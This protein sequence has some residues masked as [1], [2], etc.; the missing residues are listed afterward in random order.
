[1]IDVTTPVNS[2]PSGPNAR[3][4]KGDGQRT[5]IERVVASVNRDEQL[6][7]LLDHFKFSTAQAAKILECTPNTIGYRRSRTEA[8][9]HTTL[10]DQVD[11]VYYVAST[12]EDEDFPTESIRDWLFS[13]SSY[14]DSDM[15]A[16]RLAQG[17]DEVVLEAGRCYL[18]GYSKND[19]LEHLEDLGLKDAATGTRDP[20]VV[21]FP[22]PRSD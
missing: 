21:R 1:M 4:L 9:R 6:R 13:R 20:S 16:A 10:D 11:A 18:A 22:A 12:L 17:D 5:S 15:P 14:F 8:S 3:S 19:F 2:G 7:R